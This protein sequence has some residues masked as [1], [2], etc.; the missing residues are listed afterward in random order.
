[1]ILSYNLFPSVPSYVFLF[2]I[3]KLF[4]RTTNSKKKQLLIKILKIQRIFSSNVFFPQT[5][6]PHLLCVNSNTKLLYV[7]SNFCQHPTTM[8]RAVL[9]TTYNFYVFFRSCIY[10]DFKIRVYLSLALEYS[11]IGNETFLL[12]KNKCT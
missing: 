2:T 10:S 3:F 1:M 11:F 4:C 9:N 6:L 12:N 8:F 5:P 7:H